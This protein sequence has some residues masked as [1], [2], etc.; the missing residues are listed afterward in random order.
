M[1][2]PLKLILLL[3]IVIGVF[4]IAKM[5]RGNSKKGGILGGGDDFEGLEPES[6]S[7][8]MEKCPACGTFVASLEDH[9]C[10]R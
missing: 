9:S 7:T 5:F 10:K 8:E 2:S 6:D 3:A 1:L 4:M